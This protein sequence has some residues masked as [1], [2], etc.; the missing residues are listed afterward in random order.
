MCS[1]DDAEPVNGARQAI[2]LSTLGVRAE[3]LPSKLIFVE[4]FS[5]VY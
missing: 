1:I 3:V 5:Q 4:N 2:R